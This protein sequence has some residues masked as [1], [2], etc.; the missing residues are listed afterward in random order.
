M[1]LI[2]SR[3]N[4]AH[5]RNLV[6]PKHR[7]TVMDRVQINFPLRLQITPNFCKVVLLPVSTQ[8]G[9]LCPD[10]RTISLTATESRILGAVTLKME[11]VRSSETS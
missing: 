9:R 8:C 10:E 5:F 1:C 11:P 3:R 7:T 2:S 6:I 4:T